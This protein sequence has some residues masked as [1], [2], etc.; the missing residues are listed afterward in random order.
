MHE[1]IEIVLQGGLPICPGGVV[2]SSTG[3]DAIYRD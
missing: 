2:A 3:Q 1:A